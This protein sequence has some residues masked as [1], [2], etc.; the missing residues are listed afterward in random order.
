MATFD[1]VVDRLERLFA[2][3]ETFDAPVRDTV[4]ALLDDVDTL[5]RLAIHRW[6]EALG[7]DAVAGTAS[8]H[9]AVEWLLDAYGVLPAT[10]GDS[11]TAVE[12]QLGRRRGRE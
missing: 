2:A 6:A 3:I 1:E 7:P 9:P 4:I 12:V 11:Q 8:A 5:H 10:K